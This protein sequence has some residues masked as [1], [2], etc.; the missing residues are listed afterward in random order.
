MKYKVGMFLFDFTW[1]ECI[2]SVK[3]AKFF[4]KIEQEL[5][6]CTEVYLFS[7]VKAE[8]SLTEI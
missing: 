2:C 3:Q 7:T 1:E 4:L 5:S 8:F 6:L